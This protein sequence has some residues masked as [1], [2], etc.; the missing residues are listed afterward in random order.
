MFDF[1]VSRGGRLA[2]DEAARLVVRPLMSALAFLASQSFLHRVRRTPPSLTWAR[3][4]LDHL[5][6]CD[7]C[8]L[9]HVPLQDIKLENL[10]MDGS[11]N[12]KVGKWTRTSQLHVG[13]SVGVARMGTLR[14]LPSKDLA[15]TAGP[16]PAGVGLW[17][18]N[19]PEVRAGQHSAGHVWLLRA[20]SSRLSA[21]EGAL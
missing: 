15:L 3:S 18:R 5:G 9:F 2:E 6:V 16:P 14:F 7:L 20:R 21:Q 11:C 19:R 1:L 17:P 8:G 4:E 10:L 13:C 12:L